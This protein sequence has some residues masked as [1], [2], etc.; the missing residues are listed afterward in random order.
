[1]FRIDPPQGLRSAVRNYLDWEK[2]TP[3]E[4]IGV[5][6]WRGWMKRTL[7]RIKD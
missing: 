3:V 1:V 7:R 6:T 4:E 5:T 2:V